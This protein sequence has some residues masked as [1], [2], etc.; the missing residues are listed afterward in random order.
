MLS[1]LPPELLRDIIEATVP[2]S[3]HSNTY[4]S[5]QRT[6]RSLS[7]VSK[8]FRSIAQPLLYQIIWVRSLQIKRLLSGIDE[9][10]GG[11]NRRSNRIRC[12]VLELDHHSDFEMLL[13]ELHSAASLTLKARGVP[14]LEVFLP[15]SLDRESRCD[16]QSAQV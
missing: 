14:Q 12:V 9:G 5:R 16:T 10:G 3:F 15:S 8:L 2:H 13:P 11:G 6:L 7:L 4:K 1:S